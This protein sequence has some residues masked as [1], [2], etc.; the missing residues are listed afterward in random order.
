MKKMLLLFT[1]LLF[2]FTA[3]NMRGVRDYNRKA[4]GQSQEKIEKAVLY[5][6]AARNW[7]CEEKPGGVVRGFLQKGKYY[8]EV[9]MK[10]KP[11]AYTFSYVKTE[12]LGYKKKKNKVHKVYYKWLNY[13]QKSVYK[14]L[15]NPEL[16]EG[17]K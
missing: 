16:L 2:V 11:E 9:D 6:C 3:C 13:L 5:A 12:N 1:V 17:Q 15:A 14:G 7:V 10:A 8:V 4:P